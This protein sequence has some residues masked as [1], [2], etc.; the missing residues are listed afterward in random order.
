[1]KV[2]FCSFKVIHSL[3]RYKSHGILEIDELIRCKHVFLTDIAEQLP[4]F[5]LRSINIQ[6][7]LNLNVENQC[8]QSR[9]RLC[10]TT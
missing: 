2:W 5:N 10:K 4:L 1:M 7:S 9:C 8:Y 3:Y 6:Y